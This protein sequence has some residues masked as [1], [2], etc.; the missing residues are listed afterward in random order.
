MTSR[1]DAQNSV[2][3][4]LEYILMLK[5]VLVTRP[6]PQA[7]KLAKT[8]RAADFEPIV[9]PTIIVKPCHDVITSQ[10]FLDACAIADLILFTSQNVVSSL[11]TTMLTALKKTAASLVAIG[12]S[13]A[14][15]LKAHDLPVEYPNKEPFNSEGLLSLPLLEN[16]SA[17]KI[18]LCTG[19][20]YH[21]IIKDVLQRRG[22]TLIH[23]CLYETTCPV[24]NEKIMLDILSEQPI[25]TVII[26]SKQCLKNLLQLL[27]QRGLTLLSH[28][29]WIVASERIAH[30]A[31]SHKLQTHVSV[32]ADDRNIVLTLKGL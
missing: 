23:C 4:E 31:R 26:T 20:T 1:W 32:G 15:A 30:L 16:V 17:K 11:S 18:L 9:F 28:A 12:N 29:K 27:G 10:Q 24:I 22:A 14:E 19:K 25:D 2:L 8:L 3:K 7:D 13:T 6:Q 5:T 21:P